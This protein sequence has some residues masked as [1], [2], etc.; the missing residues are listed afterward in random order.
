[1]NADFIIL[2]FIAVSVLLLAFAKTHI[3]FVIL[4]LCTGFV[5][6]Q[7]AGESVVDFFSTWVSN[8]EF[9]LY[10]VVNIGLILVPALIVGFRFRL[11]QTG[12]SRF[13]QQLIP[14]LALTMLAVVFI[15]DVIPQET[16]SS[17]REESYLVGSFEDFAPI[18]VLFAVGAALFDV[19]FKH[20]KMHHKHHK[21]GPGRP[22]KHH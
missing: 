21:R 15:V 3:A 9:P 18:L 10:E 8:S 22:R 7:F 13:V 14:A 6:S 17:V 4:A 5:L 19:M 1:M 20:A 16:S 12:V 2:I 11:T